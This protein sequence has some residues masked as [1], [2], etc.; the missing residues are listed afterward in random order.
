MATSRILRSDGTIEEVDVHSP[1]KF[2]D[3]VDRSLRAGIPYLNAK[4]VDPVVEKNRPPAKEQKPTIASTLVELME[5]NREYTVTEINDLL[6]TK[7]I[8]NSKISSVMGRHEKNFKNVG[9]AKWKLIG[10]EETDKRPSIQTFIASKMEP[11]RVY[12]TKE[13]N[14]LCGKNVI[15]SL[16]HHTKIFEFVGTGLNGKRDYKKYWK[17]AG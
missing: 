5:L 1:S 2:F 12:S 6:A 11:G 15:G 8:K 10:T 14:E 17:L 4:M 7:G 13:V 9:F 3:A 16:G